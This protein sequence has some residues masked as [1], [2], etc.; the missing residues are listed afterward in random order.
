MRLPRTSLAA[1]SMQWT[2]PMRGSR[3][4][5]GSPSMSPKLPVVYANRGM[6]VLFDLYRGQPTGRPQRRPLR[7]SDQFFNAR[8]SYSNALLY[9]SL[10][11]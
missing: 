10:L 4:A 6:L 9:A 2:R 1:F 11:F 7:L 5:F 8:E 3:R